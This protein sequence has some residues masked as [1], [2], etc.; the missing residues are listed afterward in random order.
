M[1]ILVQKGGKLQCVMKANKCSCDFITCRAEL[2]VDMA[3]KWKKHVVID[4]GDG[5]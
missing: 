3:R 1:L 4:G 2:E 5:V